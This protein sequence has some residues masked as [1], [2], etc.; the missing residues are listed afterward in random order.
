MRTWI[1]RALTAWRA[2]PAWSQAWRRG[3]AARRSRPGPSRWTRRAA[4][5][6]PWPI[7][8][9]IRT[10]P[11]AGRRPVRV[12][13]RPAGHGPQGVASVHRA[14]QFQRAYACAS[15][16]TEVGVSGRRYTFL[17]WA[18][19]RDPDQAFRPTVHG[20]PMRAD[21]TVTASFAVACAVTPRLV[22]QNGTS[23]PAGQVSRITLLSSLGQTV[24]LSPSGTTWLP[25]ASPVYRDSLL[26]S[27][28]LQYSVQSVIVGGTNVVHAGVER[29]SPSQTPEPTAHRV[30]LRADHHRARR[31]VRQRAGQLRAADNAG[32]DRAAGGARA[33]AHR[34]R[35]RSS[36]R[37]L[38]GPGQGGRR[39]RIRRDRALVPRR[40][41]E[42][43]RGE[44]DRHRHRRRGPGGRDRRRAAAVTHPA[45][46]G[47][48]PDAANRPGGAAR[49]RRPRPERRPGMM[50]RLWLAKSRCQGGLRARWPLPAWPPARSPARQCAGGQGDGRGCQSRQGGTGNS[51]APRFR[52]SL[53]TTSGSA[54]TPGPGPRKTCP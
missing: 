34:D 20:L 30:L 6:Q 21:Y 48:R 31:H 5:L 14:A 45:R 7:T 46:P 26:S 2:L 51:A 36:T 4:S 41:G 28:S 22:E 24:T 35:R 54:I 29:F 17:R 23:L 3:G 11:G 25:C 50:T 38:P 52:C 42:P 15:A 53:T 37:G 8:L 33:T 13:R 44:P 27:R 47:S 9:T 39:E 10:V 43:D 40:D 32:P 49:R 16:Q 18:G 19:Q 12:R 1:A